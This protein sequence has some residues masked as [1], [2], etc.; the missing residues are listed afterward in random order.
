M[1]KKSNQAIKERISALM[2]G[3]VSEFEAR[4]VL[5]ELEKDPSLREYWMTLQ[6]SSSVIKKEVLSSSFRD[7]SL[8]VKKDLSDNFDNVIPVNTNSRY[9]SLKK[10]S[11]FLMGFFCIYVASYVLQ[12]TNEE[13]DY[14]NL[15]SLEIQE[16]ISSSNA[17]DVL[18]RATSGLDLQIEDI[19]AGNNGQV[20]AHYRS[21][22]NKTLKVSLSPISAVSNNLLNSELPLRAA[23]I[24]KTRD[25]TFLLD[26]K[27]DISQH[28]KSII[29]H[30]ADFIAEPE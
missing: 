23:F 11:V 6:L 28:E 21:P 14:S 19:Q 8:K 15:V 13:L 25:G 5:N 10:S 12:D 9:S 17:I 1:N 7:I 16:I 20:Y 2:D 3:E 30:N 24:I 27:G 4:R 18:K 29:L 22:S 26:V